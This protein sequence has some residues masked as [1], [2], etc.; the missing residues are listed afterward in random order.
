ME[1]VS[2][3]RGVGKKLANEV[4]EGVAEVDDGVLDVFAAWDFFELVFEFCRGFAVDELA[5]AFVIVIDDHG[6]EFGLAGSAFFSEGMFVDSDDFGPGVIQLLQALTLQVF[7][8]GGV[9]EP[10]GALV[11]A[12]DTLEVDEGFAGPGDGLD[13]AFG[14][15]FA[16][17]DAG[18]GF[19][20]GFTAGFAPESSLTNHQRSAVTADGVVLHANDPVIVGGI[21]G[22]G[23]LGAVFEPANLLAVPQSIKAALGFDAN[24]FQLGQK[25]EV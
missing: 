1:L 9:D 8:I 11:G 3:Q 5:N 23:A 20:E 4:F 17:L 15:A 2:D 21:R 24:E 12:P 14:V 6:G 18:D 10:G 25:D 19:G 7:V 16:F 22:R 13:V